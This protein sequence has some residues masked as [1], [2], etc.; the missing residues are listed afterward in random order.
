MDRRDAL[1]KLAAT[2]AIAASAPAILSST[3]FADGGTVNCQPLSFPTDIT[4]SVAATAVDGRRNSGKDYVN[5]VATVVAPNCPTGYNTRTVQY[6]W[7]V[8]GGTAQVHDGGN[9]TNISGQWG[10]VSSVRIAN[11]GSA[12]TLSAGSYTVA[13]QYRVTCSNGTRK[14]WKCVGY[15]VT[16]TFANN[17]G[18]FTL[19]PNESTITSAN[20]DTSVP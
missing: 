17:P 9:T 13:L 20:C 11:S 6:Y 18:R 19:G 8:T 15:N 2:G 5:V 1:K 14:C 12:D 4:A 16:F 3:V 10:T 7:T